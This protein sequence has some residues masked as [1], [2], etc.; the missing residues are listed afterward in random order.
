[1]AISTAAL[2]AHV[3]EVAECESDLN[4]AFEAFDRGEAPDRGDCDYAFLKLETAEMHL[5]Q[6]LAPVLASPIFVHA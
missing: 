3:A 1:M 6:F 2:N 5:A 4:E